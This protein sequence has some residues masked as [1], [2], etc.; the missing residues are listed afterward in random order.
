MHTTGSQGTP[1]ALAATRAVFNEP[2]SKQL[3][4]LSLPALN[5]AVGAPTAAQGDRSTAA[6]S[7]TGP[8]HG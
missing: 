4:W 5:R 1:K 3:A 8:R 2:G 6:L 7:Q